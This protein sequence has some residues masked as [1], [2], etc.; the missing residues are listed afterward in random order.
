IGPAAARRRLR[1]M[2]RARSRYYRIGHRQWGQAKGY[3]LSVDST[4]AAPEILAEGIA[5][6]LSGETDIAKRRAG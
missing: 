1:R 5:S 6:C 2:D 3:T 4:A